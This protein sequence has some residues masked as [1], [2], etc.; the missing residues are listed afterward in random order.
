MLSKKN[1]NLE[2]EGFDYCIIGRIQIIMKHYFIIPTCIFLCWDA[3]LIPVD[4]DFVK[5]ANKIIFDF[6]WKGKDKVKY[7]LYSHQWNQR[8]R[9]ES[10]PSR[11]YYRNT[12]SALLQEIGK[13][14]AEQLEN[15]SS[16]LP[17]TC[18]QEIS[19]MLQ[20]WIAE[21]ADKATK[22]LWWI[23]KKFCKVLHG[24]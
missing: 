3:S 4:K 9:I 18:W 20:L 6:I 17:K 24:I 2:V 10:P 23:L 1:M 14:S 7:M 5:Q 11:V 19:F 12:E 13:R 15:N 21:I 8:W 16:T 22:I